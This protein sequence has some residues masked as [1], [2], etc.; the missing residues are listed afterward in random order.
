MFTYLQHLLK[1]KSYPADV[2]YEQT[3]ISLL[4]WS[5]L[6]STGSAGRKAMEAD[7]EDFSREAA[8]LLLSL[9]PLLSG[10]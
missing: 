6:G 2:P 7:K 10:V 8:S 9:C 5:Q 1:V 4:V 3:E